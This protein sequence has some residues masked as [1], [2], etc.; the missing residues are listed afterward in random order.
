M[1]HRLALCAL[2]LI[3][4]A[5][6]RASAVLIASE[7]GSGNTTAPADD[8]GFAHVGSPGIA[9]VVYLGNG[10]VLT[11]NHVADADVTLGGVVYP[12][13]PGS[14]VNFTNP[15]LTLPDIVA[16]RIDPH[17]DL[18]ILPIAAETPA[19]GTPV[20]MIGH[21]LDRGAAT[22]WEGHDGFFVVGTQSVRW[23]SNEIAGAGMVGSDAAIATTF[24]A[25][26]TEHEAQAQYGDS[27]GAVFA[28]NAQNS[29]ELAGIIFA[30]D[31]Y[32]DQPYYLA[33]YGN[34][35]YAID[36][37]A[38]R[39][40]IIATVRPE[41]SDEAENDGDGKLD[42]PADPGCTSAAD[43]SEAADCIDGLD[44]DGDGLVDYG[45]DPGCRNRQ[46]WVREDPACDNGIDDDGDSLVD[47]ADPECAASP[48][49]WTDEGA[50]YPT[51]CGIGF[52]LV[53][54]IPPLAALR[55]RRARTG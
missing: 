32:E 35:T 23:G 30:I 46:E 22:S 5:A 39:D 40:Q 6:P 13:V 45:T 26:A 54:V 3:F 18:P 25:G 11:A 17:P 50:P 51:G 31:T 29:W 2:I 20:V 33:L 47:A 10:W 53:L 7:P 16:Y 44:N 34:V 27:G 37:S 28:K 15:D 38:Y 52:E 49:W 14:R 8:P 43:L 1:R 4:G 12:R 36:L 41:C 48:A 24:D 19:D 42:F 55:R 9:T 21:G